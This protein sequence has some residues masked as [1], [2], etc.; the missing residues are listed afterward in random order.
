[1]V[2]QSRCVDNTCGTEVRTGLWVLPPSAPSSSRER[3]VGPNE[4]EMKKTDFAQDND[5]TVHGRPAV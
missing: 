2:R 4:G 5:I 3:D 1:M